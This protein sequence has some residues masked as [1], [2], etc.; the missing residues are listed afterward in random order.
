MRGVRISKKEKAGGVSIGFGGENAAVRRFEN[1][2]GA[3]GEDRG[4]VFLK[5]RKKAGVTSIGFGGEMRERGVLKNGRGERR[6]LACAHLKTIYAH[7]VVF[8][9]ALICIAVYLFAMMHFLL[10]ICVFPRSI[11]ILYQYVT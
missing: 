2:A 10:N 1:R 8:L 6:G 11:L 7:L 4:A 5:K 3:K 9:I